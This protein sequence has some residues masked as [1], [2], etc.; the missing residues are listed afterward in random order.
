MF[1][2]RG[3]LRG[4]ALRLTG[5]LRVT[6]AFVLAAVL[7]SPLA[8]QGVPSADALRARLDSVNQRAEAAESTYRAVL[9]ELNS[10]RGQLVLVDGVRV[11]FTPMSFPER[12][13]QPV[14]AGVRQARHTLEERFGADGVA[15]LDSV[16]FQ[17]RESPQQKFGPVRAL[18]TG[19]FRSTDLGHVVNADEVERFVLRRAA[20][21]LPEH[22][23]VLARFTGTG[24]EL[25]AP[26]ESFA[27]AARELALSRSS[28]GRRC[29]TGDMNACRAV[30]AEPV[31]DADALQLWY[32]P[33]DYRAVVSSTAIP[34]Q[35]SV[36]LAGRAT[37]AAGDDDACAALVTQLPLRNP[38][39][40]VVRITLAEHALDIA[41]RNALGVLSAADSASLPLNA[42]ARAAGVPEDSLIAG[43]HRR[44][45]EALESGRPSPLLLV[46]S[47]AFWGILLLEL[48]IRRRPL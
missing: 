20:R 33:V 10:E 22:A 28:A 21:A 42:L 25:T 31:T 15:L 6:R 13:R 48:A 8:A 40:D 9:D 12:H 14:L 17:L 35:D 29:Y 23:P 39:R 44:T 27:E 1:D 47:T 11:A 37:C 41:P 45:I 36:R 43:W 5:P 3:T 34:Q 16:T 7:G 24:M 19:V 30:F 46:A 4:R 38:Y 26:D 18:S 2:A 32:E